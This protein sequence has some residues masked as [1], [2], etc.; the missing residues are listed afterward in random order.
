MIRFD[1]LVH[2][3]NIG[4]ISCGKIKDATLWWLQKKNLDRKKPLGVY[5]LPLMEETTNYIECLL[6]ELSN[7]NKCNNPSL[8]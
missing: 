4:N 1:W 8:V 5:R 6:M 2:I 3:T 7:S